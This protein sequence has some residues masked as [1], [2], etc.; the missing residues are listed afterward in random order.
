MRRTRGG[1]NGRHGGNL[2]ADVVKGAIAGAAGV[3]A[4]DRVGWWLWDQQD[5]AVLQQERE[6]RVEGMD[7]AH[8]L[9]NRAAE[10]VGTSLSPRQPHPAGIGVHYAI[11]MA[12]AMGYAA[13]RHRVAGLDAGRGL[14]YGLGLFLLV[15]EGVVPALGL[16]AAPTEYPWQAHARGLVTHLVLGLVTDTVLDVLNQ[17]A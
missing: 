2:A 17:V 16:G 6:A 1:R 12:P 13:L 5:S 9:A 15:D 10:A 7:P 8:V 4:M 3:W 11:G 14:L